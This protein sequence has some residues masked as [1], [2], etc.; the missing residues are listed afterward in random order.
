MEPDWEGELPAVPFTCVA[1]AGGPLDD[2]SF[3]QG[4]RLGML[5]VSMQMG[6]QV[7]ADAVHPDV[8]HQLDLLAMSYGYT[9]EA[10][11]WGDGCEWVNITL[12]RGGSNGHGFSL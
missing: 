5:V 1:S 6:M 7:V 3:T 9:M 4:Y 8:V 12:V 2:H 11:P 10:Q